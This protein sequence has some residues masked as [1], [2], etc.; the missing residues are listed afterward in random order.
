MGRP[1]STRWFARRRV[2]RKTAFHEGVEQDAEGPGIRRTA[3]V[4]L[5]E[6]DLRRGVV[7]AAAAGGEEG[8]FGGCWDAAGEAEVGEGDEGVGVGL[9]R[10]E[11]GH[12]GDGYV[13]ENVLK[14]DVAVHNQLVMKISYGA[15]HF[16]KDA[17][18]N[19]QGQLVAVVTGYIEKI[20][21]GA[22]GDHNQGLGFIVIKSLQMYEGRMGDG[23]QY[24]DFSLQTEFDAFLVGAAGWTVFYDFDRYELAGVQG[25]LIERVFGCGAFTGG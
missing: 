11:G 16:S 14:L 18:D 25:S 21:T 6:E 17:L 19:G 12:G 8:G 1:T 22:I 10:S 23:S 9:G 24:F 7:F 2:K 13:E 15:D 3:I 5:A 4:G 20:T